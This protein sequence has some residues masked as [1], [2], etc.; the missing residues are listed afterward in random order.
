MMRVSGV[1]HKPLWEACPVAG[2]LIQQRGRF[3]V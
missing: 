3:E 1:L 2:G